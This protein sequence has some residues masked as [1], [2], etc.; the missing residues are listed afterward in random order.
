MLNLTI[1]KFPKSPTPRQGNPYKIP[2][3]SGDM[4][5]SKSEV[6]LHDKNILVYKCSINDK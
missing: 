3:V 5:N 1:S 4:V 6:L 2:G